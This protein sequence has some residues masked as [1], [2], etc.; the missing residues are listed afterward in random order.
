MNYEQFMSSRLDELR[1]DGK[2][3]GCLPIS[4]ASAET[5]PGDLLRQRTARQR[6]VTVWCSND[7]LGMGQN[8]QF[9]TP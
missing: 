5:S 4:S 9:W 3:S 2:L 8:Q 7:Y 6:D 1:G